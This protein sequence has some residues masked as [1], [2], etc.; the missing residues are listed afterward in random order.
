MGLLRLEPLARRVRRPFAA[1]L[2][3]QGLGQV[4]P[5]FAQVFEL[6]EPEQGLEQVQALPL[7]QVPLPGVRPVALVAQAA[8]LGLELGGF[9]AAQALPPV[10]ADQDSL[11][12]NLRLRVQ[13]VRGQSASQAAQNHCLCSL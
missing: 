13:A 6:Q 3:A 10:P 9:C 5:E 12:H 4:S 7:G 11:Q 2:A 1:Q 8:D